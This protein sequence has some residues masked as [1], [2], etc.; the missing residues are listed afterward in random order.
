[1]G[2]FTNFFAVI[3][4]IQVVDSESM[5]E[6]NVYIPEQDPYSLNFQSAGYSTTLILSNASSFL[7]NTVLHFSLAIALIILYIIGAQ[8]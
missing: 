6:E 2:S 4:D 1:M 8:S 7:F 5:L 3:T